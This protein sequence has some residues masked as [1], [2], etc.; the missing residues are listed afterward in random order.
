[1]SIKSSSIRPLYARIAL[2]MA[3]LIVGTAAVAPFFFS[4]RE[5]VPGTDQVLR[6][7]DTH[8]LWMHLFIMEEFD[9]VLGS[10]V[11]Y[12]RWIPDINQG[13]GLLNMIYYP[14]GVF[15]LS[16]AIHTIIKDWHYVVFAIS[17]LALA[18]SGLA[19]YFLA[20][21]FYSRTA[22]AIA[23]LFYMLIPFHMLDLYYRGA[24]PQFVGYVFVPLIFYF[25]YRLGREGRPRYYAGLGLTFGLYLLTHL[26]VSLMLTY[27]IAFLAIVW[28]IKERDLRIGIRLAVGLS[29]GLI[30]GAIYWLPAA[31][32][33]K[34][35]FEYASDW[36]PYHNYK[37]YITLLAVEEG[38]P[39]WT[40]WKLLNE[41]FVAHALA[42]IAPII[43]L[44]ILPKRPSED[45]GLAKPP[46]GNGKPPSA[47]WA[48][49]RIWIV[50]GAVTIF[51]CTSLSI[52]ISK[53]L[54]KIDVAVPAWRWLV[55]ASVFTSLLIAA[56]IDRLRKSSGLSPQ[57]L[58]GCR[59]LLGAAI[60]FNLWITINGTML[61]ALEN[62][63]YHP[64]ADTPYGVIEPNWTP[65]G[66]TLPQ[67]LPDTPNVLM[68]P[69]GGV[70]QVMKWA[71]QQRVIS[72]K[73]DQPARMRLKTYNFRGWTAYI[74]GNKVPMLSDSDGVQIIEVP[75]G[76]H[77]VEA[78][79]LNSPP[80]TIGTIFFSIGLLAIAGLALVDRRKLR[81]EK[82]IRDSERDD[83]TAAGIAGAGLTGLRL[84][85][86]KV[87]LLA[88]GVI[89]IIAIIA[90]FL[91]A[92]RPASQNQS[93]GT[94]SSPSRSVESRSSISAGSDARLH[95][96]G[97]DFVMM[98]VDE[99]ALN[100]LIQ[101]LTSKDENKAAALIQSGKTFKVADNTRVRIVETA[102]G[103]ARVRISEGE[104]IMKEGWV[105]DRWLR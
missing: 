43:I 100:E 52:Y 17:A 8:D 14:P 6:L 9:K 29:L 51:M 61:G 5:K 33:T 21:A 68:E 38:G 46:D 40:F 28:S 62:N 41:V 101:S 74:D 89:L 79:F 63:T 19:L 3:A 88:A 31:V 92:R 25:V 91:I 75:S 7:I 11:I 27:A 86:R 102:S 56:S 13:Y 47:Y 87:K 57:M 37:S 54:P 103:M 99:K 1:M 39:Y 42:V 44:S 93:A 26:P 24:L 67:D 58:W 105:P 20:R 76:I 60:V 2:A 83:K 53:L 85:V 77:T 4:R 70:V 72:V 64:K 16:S 12:P 10:G 98:A 73:L 35:A 18:G 71:P 23:G 69:E 48:P 49:T 50:M 30:L 15:Y 94:T 81:R 84:P 55:I 34:Y 22:S 78:D 36:Y 82:A 90:V 66:S 80:R 97:R 59:A 96:D 104:D 65:K 95:I 45:F 32:E